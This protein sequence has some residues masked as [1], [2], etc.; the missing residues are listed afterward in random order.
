MLQHA[1]SSRLD[2]T[3][4]RRHLEHSLLC[5]PLS[6]RR[7]ANS[8]GRRWWSF[9]AHR[10]ILDLLGVP[11]RF[12]QGGIVVRRRGEVRHTVGS[13]DMGVF[14][15]VTL[16]DGTDPCFGQ[17]NE[18]ERVGAVFSGFVE[19]EAEEPQL[20]HVGSRWQLA[21][22][23]RPSNHRVV[24]GD[25]ATLQVKTGRSRNLHFRLKNE[26]ALLQAIEE[27]ARQPRSRTPVAKS[28]HDEARATIGKNRLH[29]DVQLTDQRVPWIRLD[30]DFRRMQQIGR[31]GVSFQSVVSK[32]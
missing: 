5:R 9:A 20:Q 7:W 6:R 32:R 25:E 27:L 8:D 3:A 28:S 19:S 10:E 15:D 23:L 24:L 12:L 17:H 11:D 4:Q 1:I 22:L 16:K 26:M 31:C 30:I 13:S 2:G 18:R 21:G 29:L 14:E